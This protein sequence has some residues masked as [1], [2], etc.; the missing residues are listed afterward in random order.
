MVVARRAIDEHDLSVAAYT[1][2]L[3]TGIF[4]A[5]ILA[6]PLVARLQSGNLDPD[7][8]ISIDTNGRTVRLAM[9]RAVI[10]DSGELSRHI[11]LLRTRQSVRA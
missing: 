2:T 6:G 5:W 9:G 11:H 8:P 1:P 10:L 3:I 7:G 4:G